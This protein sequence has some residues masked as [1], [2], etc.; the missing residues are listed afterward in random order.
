MKLNRTAVAKADHPRVSLVAAASGAGHDHWMAGGW[1]YTMT[2][3]PDSTLYVGVTADLP[4]R[5]WAHATGAAE[6]FAMRYGL[7]RLVY[8]ARHEDRGEAIRRERTIKRWR[9]AWTVR[10]IRSTNPDWA[11]I[12]DTLI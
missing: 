4:R 7:D 3:R 9:R 12:H 8:A 2:N 11:E 10:L 6:G 1:A 5:A